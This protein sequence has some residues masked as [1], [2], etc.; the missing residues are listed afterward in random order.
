M[1]EFCFHMRSESVGVFAVLFHFLSLFLF[2]SVVLLY[3]PLFAAG[4]WPR[5][6]SF[7]PSFSTLFIH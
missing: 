6:N 3:R 7:S 2:W 1:G 5:R 4:Y